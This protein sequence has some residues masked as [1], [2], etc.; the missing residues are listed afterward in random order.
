MTEAI[1]AELERVRRANSGVLRP[2][3]VVEFARDPQTALHARFE[4]DDSR[5]AHEYRL[6]QAREVIRVTVTM[7]PQSAAPFRAY[8]SLQHDREQPGGGY[9]HVADV[10]TD[11]QLRTRML[12]EANE[13]MER[14]VAKYDALDELAGVI[15]QMRAA[16]AALRELVA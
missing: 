7:I 4:W 15:K 10:L 11:R 6:W 5:A 1:R 16:R 3:D 8:V 12:L 9:R 2:V 14:F 13:E